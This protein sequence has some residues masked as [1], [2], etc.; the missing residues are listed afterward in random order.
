M[1]PFELAIAVAIS[2]I[3]PGAALL[4]SPVF[5]NTQVPVQIRIGIA[6][7]I[8]WAAVSATQPLPPEV[9]LREAPFMILPELLIGLSIGFAVQAAFGAAMVAGEV[10]GNTMGMGFA[11]TYGI[12]GPSSLLSSLMSFA[13]SAI[14]LAA[15]GHLT[16]IATIVSSFRA[17]P[18]GSAFMAENAMAA[19]GSALFAGA[20]AIALPVTFALILVQ[21]VLALIARAAPALN[22][23]AIGFP[24]TQLVGAFV[25]V[26]AF[27][28]MGEAIALRIDAALA[29]AAP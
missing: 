17:L 21:I 24:F 29:L 27:P 6:I 4:A 2:A 14:F 12:A 13:S 11:T 25:L 1:S 26:V 3:R 16:L 9:L 18:L 10:I 5:S 23:F 22:L 20:V 19:F 15:Q 28:A 8:G 7:A